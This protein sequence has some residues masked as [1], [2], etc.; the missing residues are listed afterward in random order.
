M[1]LPAMSGRAARLAAAA[2]AAPD[3]MPTSSPSS[4]ASA[5]A[6]SNASSS[7]TVKISSTTARSNVSGTK[8]A[9]IPWMPCAPARPSDS[10]GEAAG[11]TATMRT[12]GFCAF[13]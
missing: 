8:L 1:R 3:E 6:V 2:A 4:R 10:R 9:P 13:R 12:A 5:R 11:S 7:V